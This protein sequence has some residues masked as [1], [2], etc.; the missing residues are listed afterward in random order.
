LIN[1]FSKWFLLVYGDIRVCEEFLIKLYFKATL[2]SVPAEITLKSGKVK[3]TTLPLLRGDM[4]PNLKVIIPMRDDD[5]S[6]PDFI[7][8]YDFTFGDD[9][10]VPKVQRDSQG[11]TIRRVERI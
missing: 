10:R 6:V 1:L 3:P 5:E 8:N 9:E 7:R 4:H 11:R 2:D